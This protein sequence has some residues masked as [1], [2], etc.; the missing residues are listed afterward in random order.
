[1]ISLI[2]WLST[3]VLTQGDLVQRTF[4]EDGRWA[5][6]VTAWTG[7][8]TESMRVEGAL[9][10]RDTSTGKG[11]GRMYLLEW[12]ADPEQGAELEARVKAVSCSQAWGSGLMVSDGVHEE[13]LTLYP[14]RLLLVNAKHE[15]PFDA[16]GDFHTYRLAVQGEDL[17]LQV[18][19]TLLYEG[20]GAFTSPAQVVPPRNRGALAVGSLPHRA[21]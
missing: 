4:Y 2:G 18:D 13:S 16:A 14:D 6:R 19:G 10:V 11:S 9:R 8:G 20:L 7:D 1:M 21:C 17:R 3:G 5:S 12:G 15:I